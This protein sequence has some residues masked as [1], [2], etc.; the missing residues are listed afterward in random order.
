M[1]LQSYK[2]STRLDASA[3]WMA[4]LEVC[5]EQSYSEREFDPFLSTESQRPAD[6]ESKEGISVDGGKGGPI[7]RPAQNWCAKLWTIPGERGKVPCRMIGMKELL[8]QH[9]PDGED[10]HYC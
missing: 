4:A 6:C 10:R 5:H 3:A 2:A 7:T 9:R 8:S 1:I